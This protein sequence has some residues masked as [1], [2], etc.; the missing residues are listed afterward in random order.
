[1]AKNNGL[2]IKVKLEGETLTRFL[3][4]KKALGLETN[5]ETIRLLI[6]QAYEKMA[7]HSV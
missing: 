2:Q 1:M 7:S 3:Y 5:S 6:T 4:I